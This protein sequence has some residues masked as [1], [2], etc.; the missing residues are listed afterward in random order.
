MNQD[1]EQNYYSIAALVIYRNGHDS[2]RLLK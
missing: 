1:F 2:I